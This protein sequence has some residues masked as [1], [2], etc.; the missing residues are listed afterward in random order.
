VSNLWPNQEQIWLLKASLSSDLAA[1]KAWE[2]WSQRIDF[3]NLDPASYKLLPLVARNPALSAI[4]DPILLKCRGIYRQTWVI[5]HL[6]WKKIRPFL[7]ALLEAGVKKIVLL[8]GSAMMLH[9]YRDFGMRMMSDV[10]I[11]I[12]KEDIP[13]ADKLFRSSGWRSHLP[14]FNLYN[15]EHLNRW[16]ALNLLLA[17]GTNLDLHWSLIQEN[18]PCL[19]EAVLK[20]ALL[21]HPFYIPHPTDLFLQTS[22]HGMKYSSVPLIRWI[23]DAM[24]ILKHSEKQMD[25]ERLIDQAKK[26]RISIPLFSALQF[27]IQ[28]FEAPI[29]Q[30]VLQKLSEITPTR[31]ERLEYQCN[32]KG[33]SNLAH[34][35]RRCLHLGRTTL[36]SQILYAPIYLKTIARIPSAWLLPFFGIYWLGKRLRK[37]WIR[38][39]GETK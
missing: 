9:Y 20:N 31:L 11:L 30:T 6:R 22:I 3:E 5:N 15:P 4:D 28:H 17:D 18:A 34:W 23:A 38:F 8:K 21:V 26:A 7:L 16:H 39:S 36:I 10:D 25:W 12:E 14:R 24:T 19:D 37:Y 32:I 27:L 13:L 35:Y 2:N 33:Q 29:P 1:H